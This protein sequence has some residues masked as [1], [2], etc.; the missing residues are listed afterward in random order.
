MIKTA[1]MYIKIV[2]PA[3]AVIAGC[4]T[5]LGIWLV[6]TWI[7]GARVFV[8]PPRSVLLL[9]AAAMAAASYGNVVNDMLDVESDRVS[10]PDRPLA[11]GAMTLRAAAFLAAA[12]ALGSLA[13]AAAAS[14]FHATAALIPIAL[15]TMYSIYFKRTRVVGNIVVAALTGYALLFGSLP[16]PETK[17][18]FA[19]ALLAILLNFCREVVKDVQD[20]EGD[21]AAGWATSAALPT[22]A[23]RIMLSSVGAIY[24]I[25][26]WVP[27]VMLGHFGM[28]YSAVCFAAVLP[29]HVYWMSLILRPELDKNVR[30]AGAVLKLEM[31]AG[32]AALALDRFFIYFIN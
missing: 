20:A 18:L 31:V 32:M 14:T 27:S 12:L 29:L 11:N 4:A 16:R 28:T 8:T 10:H 1:V 9:A 2:R 15:L 7:T 23:I 13:C 5:A 25:L 30:R 6:D 17:I 22:R 19:P 26:M 24:I 21:R 3:N